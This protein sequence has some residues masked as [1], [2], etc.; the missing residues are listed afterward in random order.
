MTEPAKKDVA[1]GALETVRQFV[2]TYDIED[3]KDEIA[4]PEALSA[5]LGAHDL[6]VALVAE[7]AKDGRVDVVRDGTDRPIGEGRIDPPGV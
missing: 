7:V 4:S 2:N 5:W 6:P 1:P 3:D